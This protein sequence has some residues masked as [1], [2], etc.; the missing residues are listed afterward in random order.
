MVCSAWSHRWE[1]YAQ[2]QTQVNI[3]MSKSL[4]GVLIKKAH[5]KQRYTKK[6]LEEFKMCADSDHGPLYFLDNFFNIQHPTQG[7]IQYHPFE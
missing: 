4:D 6:Q 2:V 1:S 5:K 3:Y 7:K